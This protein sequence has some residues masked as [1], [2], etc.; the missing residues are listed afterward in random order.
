V[1]ILQKAIYK[2]KKTDLYKVCAVTK[3]RNRINAYI[4]ERKANLLDFILINIYKSFPSALSGARYFLKTVDN[5]TR[6]FWVMPLYF[7]KEVKST[8]EKWRRN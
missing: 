2:L 6:K 4:S 5:Y 7:R 1:I 3:M 8:L